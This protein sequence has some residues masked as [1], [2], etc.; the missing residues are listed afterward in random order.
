LFLFP[1]VVEVPVV[2]VPALVAT[3]VHLFINVGGLF[4]G[5]AG[6][7]LVVP[8]TS[9]QISMGAILSRPPSATAASFR[10]SGRVV[11]VRFCENEGTV[12][13]AEVRMFFDAKQLILP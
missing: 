4:F 5:R 8:F 1:S 13:V 2:E 11:I 6:S 10:F 12:E 3:T 9:M 7:L